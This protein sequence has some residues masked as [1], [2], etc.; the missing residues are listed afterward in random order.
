MKFISL[1]LFRLCF[2][3]DVTL[4]HLHDLPSQQKK[5]TL[6]GWAPN[7]QN[8]TAATCLW[9]FA[10]IQFQ[11]QLWGVWLQLSLYPHSDRD[12]TEDD[13][14][15]TPSSALKQC[16]N[17]TVLSR[18]LQTWP[19]V[20]PVSSVGPC[21]VTKLETDDKCQINS[22]NHLIHVKDYKWPLGIKMQ[23]GDDSAI[24]YMPMEMCDQG[25]HP[26]HKE[27][28]WGCFLS[29]SLGAH[30]WGIVKR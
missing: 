20:D 19:R 13:P 11:N 29:G 21:W 30:R 16:C 23:S 9:D 8:D 5:N 17:T 18:R 12:S 3:H 28:A 24:L 27:L 25:Y 14:Q 10:E 7:I 4:T 15:A 2:L 26:N 6:H 22:F 1:I